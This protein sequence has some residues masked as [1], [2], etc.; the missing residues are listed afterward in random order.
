MAKTGRK[1]R[2]RR[3]SLRTLALLLLLA[4]LAG[5]SACGQTDSG[6]ELDAIL[7][8]TAD[9]LME[10]VPEP[11]P[12]SVGG[13]WLI[14]G[15]KRSGV[16]VPESYYQ[17]Y[18]DRLCQRVTERQG[19]LDARKNTEYSRTILALSA[20]G[21]DPGDV[22]GYDLLRPLSDYE[23]TLRQGINGPIFA[24]L[25]LDS[26][27]YTL[28]EGQDADNQASRERYLSAI[29]EAQNEDGS[30]SLAPGAGDADITAM[31]LQALAGYP[32]EARA[33]AAAQQG[34]DWLAGQAQGEGLASYGQENPETL[35]Q[36][37]V[38]LGSLGIDPSDE[39][40]R[41]DAG[42]LQAQ[43]LQFQLPEGG[44]CH[45]L[46]GQADLMATEQA[47]Y[48]LAALRLA[49]L[50]QPG[51][52][53]LRKSASDTGGQCTLS[54]SCANIRNEGVRCNEDKLELLPED[55]WILKP[56]T[57]DFQAGDNV[58]DVLLATCRENKIHME[59]EETPLYRSAYIEGIGNLYEFDA[60]SLSGW[61]YSVNGWFPNAGCS[62][63]A[64]R[65]GDEVC[66]VYTCDLGRDVGNAYTME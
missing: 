65:D 5:L 62:D 54:I 9:F 27:G 30:W 3:H 49:R 11:A 24:L 44:F 20:L 41:T 50:E 32:D 28:P 4:L 60:G 19:V 47:F 21:R 2:A 57:V 52:Y 63:I 48:A 59:Y 29:L 42:D 61:M 43:L 23:Q 10:T 31:A 56:Q 15:L 6:D 14:F 26:G 22:A 35:A 40:F 45:T 66:W 7:Q 53:Q 55:G 38:A 37:I 64:L 34:L 58:F 46:G 12:G 39:R 1:E 33:A 36:V 13:E 18:Y 16:S 25:A 17:G 8:Q 51:L